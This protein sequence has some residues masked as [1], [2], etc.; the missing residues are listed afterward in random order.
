MAFSRYEK[1]DLIGKSHIGEVWRCVD[2]KHRNKVAGLWLTDQIAQT[3]SAED[4]W[5][6][7]LRYFRDFRHEYVVQALD[8]DQEQRLVLMELM[9]DSMRSVLT[10]RKRIQ[11]DLVRRCLRRCL[12][13]LSDLHA[14]GLIHGDIRP[15]QLLFNGEG[16]FRLAFSVGLKPGGVIIRREKFNEY[17]APELLNPA[18][19]PV[20]PQSDLY[21][22]GM[23]AYEMLAGTE[24]LVQQVPGVGA[25]SPEPQ[26]QWLRWQAD[27][28]TKLPRLEALYQNMPKD[29]STV[30]MGLL[31]K[32]TAERFPN[33]K[34]ALA[35]LEAEGGAAGD[36]VLIP[37]SEL[38]SALP[39]I[40]SGPA[41]IQTGGLEPIAAA[42]SPA[43]IAPTPAVVRRSSDPASPKGAG[44]AAAAAGQKVRPVSGSTAAS[45]KP[46]AGQKR[47]RTTPIVLFLLLL[48]GLGGGGYVYMLRNPAAVS[49]P[50][51]PAMTATGTL[52]PTDAVLTINGV[53]VPA[54]DGRWSWSSPTLVD[55]QVKATHPRFADWEQ[56]LPKAPKVDLPIALKQTPAI[57]IG[58]TLVP[59]DA[60]LTINGSPVE[61][62][63]GRWTWSS[64]E[65]AE[66]KLKAT[67][68]G[69]ADW[70]QTVT[71]VGKIDLPITLA[72]I[73]A[74]RIQGSLVPPEAQ[75][76][77]NGEKVEVKEGVWKWTSLEPVELKV[78]ATSTGYV[79]WEQT[80]TKAGEIELPIALEKIPAMRLEGTLDPADAVLTIN[81]K[82]VE[83]QD[84]R[85][86]WSSLELA[87]LK[88]KATRKGYTDFEQTVE[89]AGD[90]SLPIALAKIPAMRLEGTLE[91]ADAVLTINGKAVEAKEG[92]WKWS[93]LEPAELKLKATRK[94]YFDFEQ[95]VVKGGELKLPIALEKI[96]A[97]QLEGTLDPPD[98]VLTINGK[99]VEAKE[100]RWKWSSLEPEQ[101]K[102][103]ATRAGY[104]DFEH[105]IAKAGQ[106]RV[107]IALEKIPA[108]RLEGT[109]D[110]ADAVLTINGTAVESSEGRWKWTSRE[111][112]ELKLKA[113]RS[114]YREWER[115]IA[116]A[117]SHRLPISLE[118]IPAIQLEGTLDPADATL[119]VNGEAVETKE[120]RWEWKSLE[121]QK[122]TVKAVHKAY[123][124]WEHV[125]T[126]TGSFKVHAVLDPLLLV[127][128][129]EATVHVSGK[130]VPLDEG[131]MKLRVP[132]NEVVTVTVAHDGRSKEFALTRASI[133]E[134]RHRLVL[135]AGEPSMK[136]PGPL[137]ARF[138]AKQAKE[139]QAATAAQFGLKV[140]AK[141]SVGMTMV[142]IPAGRF[143]IGAEREQTLHANPIPPEPAEVV[144][145]FRI[146][147]TEVTQAQRAAVMNSKPWANRDVPTGDEFPAV[148]ISRKDA[149]EFC[150]RLSALE[151]KEG[152][153][154]HLGAYRL[155]TEVEWEWSCRAGTT[156][157]YSC[158]DESLAEHA[159]H[160]T[161]GEDALMVRAGEL[162]P[163]A[164]G[165]FDVHGNAGEWT[166]DVFL[167]ERPTEQ[168]P[169]APSFDKA[170]LRG[171]SWRRAST[172]VTSASRDS[173]RDTT[174]TAESGVRV[175]QVLVK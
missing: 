77:I 145:P 144:A 35:Q 64:L 118:R 85:W 88:L 91:P 33:A 126:K 102:L 18:A 67:H 5:N 157:A 134:L 37:V 136:P 128:P 48:M 115:T 164:F 106:T 79:D 63:E 89:K 148:Y 2:T 165:L 65:P 42:D 117:G 47:S 129:H 133:V 124:A 113:T 75:L 158:P 38:R 81:G 167:S 40:A 116:K 58:G 112:I 122:V 50:T 27:L 41:A 137:V 7:V 3:I 1:L 28:G 57:V 154:P 20:G 8:T 25:N 143:V 60:A 140:E 49:A 13:A 43:P 29:L 21:S 32:T 173:F 55:L 132:P 98:A 80:V 161:S 121:P 86:K 97:M 39:A 108:M 59:A 147:M 110:P 90:V 61:A 93:S 146:S 84:G 36:D 142:V 51:E 171:G 69:Y 82:P 16:R 135:P 123:A 101:L 120:G 46:V 151:T 100:G 160:L 150:R 131:R 163:N 12:T 9:R 72:K 66:L 138:N 56:M 127:E 169:V 74:I 168:E 170:I 125:L 166:G 156:S 96:A 4:A 152:P 107:P 14:G 73:P 159:R 31:Q 30:V 141:N 149:A 45:K 53:A 92:R 23:A 153:V 83:A 19:G 11:P 103:K 6:N 68:A 114:G 26:K 174:A 94:G 78:K 10:Q 139:G 22:L 109:L 172:R 54:K 24:D 130:A 162:K 155:P 62:Q 76:T 87:E 111:P 34:A 175:V 44:S 17:I 104:M 71:Q 15:D 119:T 70:E 105:T 95:T 99:P 52:E